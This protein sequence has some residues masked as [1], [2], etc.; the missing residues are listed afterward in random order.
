MSA[1]LIK[2]SKDGWLTIDWTLGLE[3]LVRCEKYEGSEI[4]ENREKR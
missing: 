3:W 4:D 2:S 1:F